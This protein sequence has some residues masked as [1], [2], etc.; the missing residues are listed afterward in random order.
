MLSDR[1]VLELARSPVG[2]KVQREP[3]IFS[4]V[5]DSTLLGIAALAFSR[6]DAAPLTFTA[7][8]K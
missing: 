7:V 6:E 2:A 3:S 4:M 8:S 5:G 1:G